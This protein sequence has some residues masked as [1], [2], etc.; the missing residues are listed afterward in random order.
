MQALLAFK[1]R[2]FGARLSGGSLRSCN[3]GSEVALQ[4]EPGNCE[5]PPG[6]VLVCCYAK[7]GVYGENVLLSLFF[8]FQCGYFLVCCSVGVTQLVSEFHG[9]E[10]IPYAAVDSM[11]SWEEMSSRARTTFMGSFFFF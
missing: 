9:E 8:P 4:E 2:C 10:I 7:Y 6:C 1:T 5:F 3:A 11:C